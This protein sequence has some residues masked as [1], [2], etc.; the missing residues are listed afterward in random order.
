MSERP[1]LEL[2]YAPR[3]RAFTALWLLEELGEP[4]TLRSFDLASER[5][6]QADFMALNPMGKVPVVIH[7]G[8][9]VSELG[10]IAIYL[11]DRFPAAKLAPAVDDP[12]RAA[13]LRW[14]FFASA[15]MEPALGEKFFKWEVPARSV[16][17]GSFAQM[18]EVLEAGVSPGPW[19]LGERFSAADAV[20]GS[21]ARFGSMFGVLPQQGPIADYLARLQARPAF[22]RAAAIEAEQSERFPMPKQG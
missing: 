12:Q 18:L 10:A 7:E 1:T 9:P 2:H 16:A 20:V 14:T 6:K 8:V 13:Y 4:Y 17:W 3:T 15:I 22:E 21:G 19:L 11:G 5:H